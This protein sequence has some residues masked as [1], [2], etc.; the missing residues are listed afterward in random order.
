MKSKIGIFEI[1]V[2]SFFY[3]LPISCILI[4]IIA[5]S[6]TDIWWIMIKWFVF[7]GVGLRLF[8]CGMKQVISPEFTAKVIF[9]VEDSKSYSVIRELGFSNI[10]AGLCGMLSLVYIKF[11]VVALFI[12]IV[13][14][15]LVLIQHAIRR[16]KNASEI[17]VTI[18]DLSIV[19]ELLL[20]LLMKTIKV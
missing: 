12:G 2:I 19:L 10:C 9:E 15:G 18:T 1:S 11:R 6:Q 16:K 4:E 8:T 13:Y 20:P 7:W 3:I 14:Y 5:F 17:F